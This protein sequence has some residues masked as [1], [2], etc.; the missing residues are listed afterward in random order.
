MEAFLLILIALIPVV[1]V[2]REWR[3]AG[4][5]HFLNPVNAFWLA[6]V[7]A[8]VAQP[9]LSDDKWIPFYGE[10]VFLQTLAMFVVLGIAFAVGYGLPVAARASHA[11]PDFPAPSQPKIFWTGLLLLGVGLLGYYL[12]MDAS[13]GPALYLSSPRENTNFDLSAYVYTLPRVATLGLMILLCHAFSQ[14]ESYVYKTSVV[15]LALL[16]LIWQAYTGT[17]EGTIMMLV[18]LFGSIYAAKR[19]NPP[20]VAIAVLLPTIFFIFGFIP[21][22][23]G[24]FRNLSF[25]L[26]DPPAQVVD[27]SFGFFSDPEFGD[28]APS[29]Y[30]PDKG[31]DL[32][33]DFGMAISVAYYVP[34]RVK[35]DYGYMLLETVT[36]G[37]PRALWPG[38]IYPESVEWDR[39]HRVTNISTAENLE[40]LR[41]G[42]S[43]TMVGK[44]FYIGGW[45]GLIL[46]GMF[47]GFCFR[48][49]W[50]FLRRQLQYVTGV[51]LLVASAGLGGMEMI[52]PLAWSVYFWLPTVFVPF[53]IFVWLSRD[54]DALR[55]H[56][57]ASS[58]TQRARH[59][60][61][62]TAATRPPMARPKI[63]LRGPMP[64]RR[65]NL[66]R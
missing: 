58:A 43:P 34:Q 35:Y 3:L 28:Q 42:P 4:G 63:Q 33:S 49:L 36:H 54:T 45:I 55:H 60:S 62:P 39:F 44:Y 30:Q 31:P 64:I 51:I 37:I 10:S 48:F 21:T 25:N 6:F 9:L 12:V 56:Q 27:R 50:E 52:H 15:V 8:G 59:D 19:R 46:G 7:Y 1:A 5:W 26:K 13:G 57:T 18:I 23:R 17:R 41:G 2:A 14:R 11:L 38:K 32:W 16:N 61:P 65:S 20:L 53:V 29:T 66:R 24:D 47:S 40:G 22:Y